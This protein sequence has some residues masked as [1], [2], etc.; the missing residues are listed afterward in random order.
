MFA[1]QNAGDEH[2]QKEGKF[3]PETPEDDDNKAQGGGQ[4]GNGVL[5]FVSSAIASTEVKLR[6]NARFGSGSKRGMARKSG[7]IEVQMM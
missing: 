1:S 7:S 4:V 3:D 5:R 6:K 2:E